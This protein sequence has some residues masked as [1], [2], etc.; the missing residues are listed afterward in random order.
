MQLVTLDNS[1]AAKTQADIWNSAV[2][3]AGVDKAYYDQ[4][5]AKWY[6]D[7]SLTEEIKAALRAG[8]M[9]TENRISHHLIRSHIPLKAM[10]LAAVW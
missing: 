10:L 7:Q 3:K 4:E 2:L 9:R 6:K 5:K 1:G 8:Q